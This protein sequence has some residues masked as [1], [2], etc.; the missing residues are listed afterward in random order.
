LDV[1]IVADTRELE[2]VR[3]HPARTFEAANRE[4][5]R[6]QYHLLVGLIVSYAFILTVTVGCATSTAPT[7]N[8]KTKILIDQSTPKDALPAWLIYAGERSL[9][10]KTKFY[11]EHPSASSYRYTFREEL[12][13]RNYCSR[14]WIELKEKNGLQ[15]RY[16]DDLILVQKS[17]FLPEYVWS[18]FRSDDWVKPEGLLLDDF[19]KWRS[20]HL[21][22]H[23]PETRANVLFT[24][25]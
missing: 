21:T 25:N 3:M 8:Q 7:L 2:V 15:N 19:D 20:V 17:G 11:Q 6:F 23:I 1:L 18:Y 12:D 9:W 4:P 13:A 24:G 22:E 16:L 14:I 10:M 5:S